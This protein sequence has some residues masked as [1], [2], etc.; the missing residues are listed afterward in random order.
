MVIEFSCSCGKQIKVSAKF[1]GRRAK[2]PGCGEPVTVPSPDVPDDEIDGD[3]LYEAL[4]DTSGAPDEVKCPNCD[5]PM[6][7]NNLVCSHCG[8]NR[9]ARSHVQLAQA[10]NAPKPKREFGGPIVTLAGIDLTWGR[11]IVLLAVVVGL[12]TWYYLGPGATLHIKELQTVNVIWTINSGKTRVPISFGGNPGINMV[13]AVNRDESKVPPLHESGDADYTLGSSDSLAVATPD[14]GGDYILLRV[15]LRQ[16][17][18][19]DAGKTALYDS[20]IKGEDFKLI[21]PDGSAPVEAQF[22]YHNFDAGKAEIDL[23]TAETSS[24][25]AL[26]PTEPTRVDVERESGGIDG[27]AV[28]HKHNAQGEIE[29]HSSYATGDF[30]AA[31][32]LSAEGRLELFNDRGATVDMYYKNGTL[33]VSWDR[34][35]SGWWAK[36]RYEEPTHDWP[37]HRYEFALLFKR[38]QSAGRYQLTYVGST[39]AT[40][41]LDEMPGLKP[42]PVSPMKRFTSQ[43]QANNPL[44]TSNNPLVYFQ[45]LADARNQAKGIVSAN[46]LRQIGLGLS[47]YLEQNNQQWPERLDQLKS[48]VDGYDQLMVNPRTNA[49]PGFIYT[50][51]EPGADPAATAVVH[52]SAYGQPDPNGAVLYA[53]GHIE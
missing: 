48:V 53:D 2:C 49:R 19:R 46:N 21:P 47:L 26:F 31:T 29:F 18:I 27:K 4:G 12:P 39:V 22:L 3:L 38:P 45:I 13:K 17:A 10:A 32:G 6:P 35:A 1:A 14:D 52:E 36:N 7:A 5:R 23:G 40:F 15:S 20:I 50:R 42:P 25:Q 41:R 51:P 33:D 30:A 37:W 16:L 44:K 24:Y 28:W 11:L 43:Q 9:V 34:D 8:Y